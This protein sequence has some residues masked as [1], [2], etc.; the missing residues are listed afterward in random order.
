MTFS[1]YEAIVNPGQAFAI[2]DCNLAIDLRSPSGLSFS[3]GSFHYQGYA[4]LDQPGMTAK[5]TAK[6]YFMGNPVPTREYR[7]DMTGPYDDSYVFSDDIGVVDLVWSPCGTSR[8]LNALTR[9]VV[10][11]NASKS[12]SGYLNTS[13]VNG[14]IKTIFRWNL[15]WRRC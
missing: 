11:N 6:Y 4:I 15:L 12:G 2:K 8:R 3:V 5:Q 14:E 9:L 1:S 13:D 7:S 10:Q